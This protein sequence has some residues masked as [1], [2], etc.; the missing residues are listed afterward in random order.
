MAHTHQGIKSCL[1][2][3][4]VMSG[5]KQPKYSSSTIPPKYRQ[6]PL[7]AAYVTQTL[8]GGQEQ[9][10]PRWHQGLALAGGSAGDFCDFNFHL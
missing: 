10:I 1:K 9:T 8:E 2:G 3:Q 4:D 6:R 7:H 5:G